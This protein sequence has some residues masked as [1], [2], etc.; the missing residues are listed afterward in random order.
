MG[1]MFHQ[2]GTTL[3]LDVGQRLIQCYEGVTMDTDDRRDVDRSVEFL[4]WDGVVWGV[5]SGMVVGLALFASLTGFGVA[6]AL[7]IADEWTNGNL[8]WF[9]RVSAAVAVLVSGMVAAALTGV[10]GLIAGSTNGMAACVLL[11]A[12]SLVAL[13]VGA[14][15][16]ASG[17]GA[18]SGITGMS[19]SAPT[20]S[21]E[22]LRAGAALWAGFW[23]ML[24]ATAASAL[25]GVV[26]D[27]T[28]RRA[29]VPGPLADARPVPPRLDR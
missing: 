20:D 15:N 18:S 28:R 4:N 2:H 17:L 9:V 6:L 12:L 8:A 24:V 16:V 5:I 22:G 19:V 14:A 23:S 1:V 3:R 7:G 10:R 13:S 26:A 29:D 25:G 11:V 21:G 27:A